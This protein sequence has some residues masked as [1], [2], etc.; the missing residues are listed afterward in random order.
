[1]LV[2]GAVWDRLRK[3]PATSKGTWDCG[4]QAPTARIQYTGASFA[5]MLTD[6]FRWVLRPTERRPRIQGLFPR[7]TAF[8]AKTPDV[9]LEGGVKPALS[10]TAWAMS[11][12]RILQAGH[13]PI[14]LLYV[15]LTLVALFAWT[16]A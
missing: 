3:A 12:L 2:A 10:F 15:V 7:P 9:I 5:Q 6:S 8:R 11:W 1:L 4:F 14:Y 16:L 13:L